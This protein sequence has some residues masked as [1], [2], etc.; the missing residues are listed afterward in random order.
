MKQEIESRQ[1]SQCRHWR[2]L[3]HHDHEAGKCW[4]KDA[5]PNTFKS[6]T[7]GSDGCKRWQSNRVATDA[8]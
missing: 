1:C 8:S 5:A 6:I 2:S 3:P 4:N 7:L